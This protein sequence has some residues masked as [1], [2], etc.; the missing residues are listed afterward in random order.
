MRQLF[1]YMSFDKAHA[2]VES[3]EEG[4]EKCTYMNGIF[5]QAEQKNQ[6]ERVYPLNEI[7]G[8]VRALNEKVRN[9]FS[10]LGELDHPEE[11]TINLD[12]ASHIITEMW[13]DG[14]DGYGKLKILPTPMGKIAE[15]MLKSG[16]KLGVSSRG[17]GNVSDNGDVSEF[18][19][20]TVDIVAQP[21][22]PNAY[23]KAIYES[24]FNMRGGQQLHEMAKAAS[25]SDPIAERYIHKEVISFINDLKI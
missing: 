10:V 13:M 24:L 7:A 2:I 16:V 3:V 23:P 17:S 14:N 8:A 15:T 20:V 11:L 12:R 21:S 25:E 1:E 5:I 22:A 9:G 19:I 6:N 4:G 18:E